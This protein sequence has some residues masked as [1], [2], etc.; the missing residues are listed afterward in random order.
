MSIDI[1]FDIRREDFSLRV[2]FSA[3]SRGV[4]ALFGPSGCGKTTLL[5]AIAGLEKRGG[6]TLVV[7]GRVWQDERHFL[8]PHKRPLGY[9]FQEASLFAHLDIRRNLEYGL[10][11]LGTKTPRV[12]FGQAVDFL[13]IGH[14]LTR[15]PYQLS[16]GERQR[17]AIGRALLSSPQV[18]LMDE[19]LAALD[20]FAK[21]EIMPCLERLYD[22]LSIPVLYVSHDM[23]EIERLADFMVLMETAKD[24]KGGQRSGRGRATGSLEDLLFDP[25]LPL[26]RMPDAASVLTGELVALDKAYGLATFRVGGAVFLVPDMRGEI[27]TRHRLRIE[28]SNVALTRVRAPQG[29]S[30][31]NGPEARIVGAQPF[32]AYQMSVFLRL[33]ADGGGAP[34]LARITRKSWDGLKLEAGDKVHAL[35]KSV[36]LTRRR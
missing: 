7:Q 24:E 17:V 1:R 16:G 25:D 20:R 23:T 29:S 2:D 27:G 34:L 15:R 11:R 13:G 9:V 10:K 31:L 30:I 12:S 32:G 33:G 3:P 35:V 5:R 14:L 19:P 18:L 6:G 8:P 21:N 26:A 4:T 28:A 36:A 22:E